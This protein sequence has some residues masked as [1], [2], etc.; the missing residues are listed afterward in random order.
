MIKN[1]F[2]E[3]TETARIARFGN[4]GFDVLDEKRSKYNPYIGKQVAVHHIYP[5]KSNLVSK[6]TNFCIIGTVE[7][8]DESEILIDV[9]LEFDGG[10]K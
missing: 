8:Q 4:R 5:Y 6:A 3:K 1:P 10:G 9:E 7:G 2:E